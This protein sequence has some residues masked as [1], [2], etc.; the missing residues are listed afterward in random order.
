[1]N[2]PR[3]G[4]PDHVNDL[5]EFVTVGKKWP[6][7][8]VTYSHTNFSPDLTEAEIRT[9]IAGALDRWAAVARLNFTETTTGDIRVGFFAGDHG[10]GTP[11][12]GNGTA[13]GNVLAHCFYPP[14]NGGDIAGDCHFD[15]AEAWSTNLPPTGVDLPT[16]ALHELGHGLGLDHSAVDNSVM[17]A[18]YGG[19]RRE[20]TDDDV[21]GIQS[22]YGGRFPDWQQLDANPATSAI[23]AANNELYQLHDTGSIWRYTGTPMTGWQQ[24]DANPATKAITAAN[25]ELYQLH[26]TGSIWRYTGTPMT[27]WQQLDANPATMTIT[28]AD[29]LYQLH[30][31]GSIWRYTGT[32]MTGWQQL[33]ANPATSAIAATGGRLYQL[34]KDGRIWRYTA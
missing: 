6:S 11:F 18:F 20:L 16:V 32:P 9:S 14:P 26:D 15:E 1:M 8:N 21:A 29:S 13:A 28:A 7:S 2:R 17:F 25:N 12:D 10:D 19:A 31:S 5:G 34:H 33:D 3:C 27:G 4:V 22:I 24:L 30:N 23:T